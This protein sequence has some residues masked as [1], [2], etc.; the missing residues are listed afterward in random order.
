MCL[1]SNSVVTSLIREVFSGDVCTL[2][3]HAD[4]G[5][6][7]ACSGMLQPNSRQCGSVVGGVLLSQLLM[8]D[9]VPSM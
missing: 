1:L 4:D 7:S 5:Y 2:G 9:C 6:V 8:C 3:P